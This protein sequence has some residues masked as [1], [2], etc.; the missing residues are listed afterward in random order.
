MARRSTF[1]NVRRLPSG[2]WQARYTGPDGQPHRAPVTFE[3]RQDA[4][5]WLS[6]KRA[7]VIRGAWDPRTADEPVTRPVPTLRAY[8]DDWLDGRELRPLT[9]QLYRVILDLHVLPALGDRLLTGITPAD[10]RT[11]HTRLG[12]TTGPTMRARSYALLKTVLGAAVTD[13]VIPSNPCRLRGASHARREKEIR[14]ATL[15]EIDVI[16]YATPERYRVLV[17]LAAW[18]GLRYGELAELRRGDIDLPGGVVRVRR[19][20]T[21]PTGQGAVVGPPKSHAGIRAVAIPPHLLGTVASHL[22]GHTGPE[23]GSLLFPSARGGHLDR[24]SAARWWYPAREAAGRPDLRLH[25][26]RHTGLTLAAVAGATVKELMVRA[27]HS[28]PQVAM[29]YQHVAQDRDQVIAA[30]LSG[31]AEGNVTPIRRRA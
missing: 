23:P 20:V 28:S 16:V 27:G 7:D 25:D 12:K 10:V 30:A 4:E 8:A 26:L 19:A 31:L 11:W 17:L 1:G 14:P 3:T 9:R 5:T 2:N 29:R 15:A 18:C 6:L 13:D 22:D 21:R 24:H